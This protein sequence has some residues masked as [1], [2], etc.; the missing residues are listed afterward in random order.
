MGFKKEQHKRIIGRAG[1]SCEGCGAQDVPLTASHLIHGQGPGS[2]Y[3]NARAWCSRCKAE[4]H[5]SN[6]LNPHDIGLNTQDALA[7][8]NGHLLSVD[9]ETRDFLEEQYPQQV[10]HIRGR[11]CR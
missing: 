10:E 4:Y 5:V 3:T 2:E 8:A 11:F 6:V 9:Q 1:G 7:T